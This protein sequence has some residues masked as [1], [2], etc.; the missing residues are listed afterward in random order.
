VAD[1][2]GFVSPT[3]RRRRLAAELRRLRD[4]SGLRGEDVAAGIGW[5]PSKVSRYEL[6]RTGLKIADVKDLLEFYGVAGRRQDEL[7]ALAAEGEGHGW[8][9]D[10]A[11]V[12]TEDQVGIMGLETE[13]ASVWTWHLDVIP[14]LFQTE[15]Y[16]R[17]VNRQVNVLVPAPPSKIERTVQARLMRQELLRREPP[18]SFRAVIDE[19]VLRRRVGE[20]SVMREQL[21]HLVEVAQLPNVSVRILRLADES[22]LIMNSF[23]LLR[24]GEDEATMLDVVWIEHLTSAV[25]FEGETDTFQYQLIFDA[26]TK[27]SL[28]PEDS[29]RLIE[30][31]ARQTW[32]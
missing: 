24:F 16:A 20:P 11:D 17:K 8:W 19:S 22:A 14:G 15:A 1:V 23:D 32:S 31:I 25:Y 27:S 30:N 18:C 10:F 6:A 2:P 29:M 12:F 5:S 13:A 3:V 4:R 21:A 7:L 26:I 28:E 9:E